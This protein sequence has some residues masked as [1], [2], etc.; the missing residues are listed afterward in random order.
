MT[1]SV[2][3]F[4]RALQCPPWVREKVLCACIAAI[5]PSSHLAL[6]SEQSLTFNHHEAAIHTYFIPCV[7]HCSFWSTFA[8]KLNIFLY[9]HCII[10]ALHARNDCACVDPYTLMQEVCAWTV[11]Y[12]SPALVCSSTWLWQRACAMQR[13]IAK[14]HSF[15]RWGVGGLCTHRGG[16]TASQISIQSTWKHTTA[17]QTS[18]S[19]QR[20]RSRWQRRLY[21]LRLSR[22]RIRPWLTGTR[23]AM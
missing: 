7:I 14:V 2:H 22:S 15:Q 8:T 5:A 16:K 1:F 6:L 11:N 19:E 13:S 21:R 3:C 10:L 12:T 4:Y 23:T 18:N 17:H 9:I 20:V